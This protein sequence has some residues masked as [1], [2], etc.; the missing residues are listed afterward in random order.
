MENAENSGFFTAENAENTEGIP[1]GQTFDC[2]P[3]FL[4]VQL[5]LAIEGVTTRAVP[6]K[7]SAFSAFSAVKIRCSPRSQSPPGG[8]YLLY[9]AKYLLE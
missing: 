9:F 1:P 8:K 7:N 3:I 2:A 4:W 6:P 5:T